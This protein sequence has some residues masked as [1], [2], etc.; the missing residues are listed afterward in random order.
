MKLTWKMVPLI[1]LCACS[2]KPYKPDRYEQPSVQSGK[3]VKMSVID[4]QNKSARTHN[5]GE[6]CRGPWWYD[7]ADLGNAFHELTLDEL[8]NYQSVTVLERKTIDDIRDKELRLNGGRHEP[9]R[10][11]AAD[12]TI[13]GTVD[14]FEYCSGGGAGRIASQ[15]SQSFLG[16]GGD[17]ETA[18]VA[19]SLRL[20]EIKTGK[21]VAASRGEGKQTRVSASFGGLINRKLDVGSSAFQQSSLGDAIR[22]AI[23]EG[24]TGLW[25]KARL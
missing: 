3:P 8:S 11:T 5:L 15:L 25:K 24:M 20:I 10:F 1:A 22:E 14:S 2:A 23:H 4:F 17:Q 7:S 6:N 16:V 18:K 21:I 12:Y 19:V 13:A 9:T